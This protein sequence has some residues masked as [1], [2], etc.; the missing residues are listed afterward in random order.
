MLHRFHIPRRAWLC[1]VIPLLALNGCSY[2]DRKTSPSGVQ[3]VVAAPPTVKTTPPE[4]LPPPIARRTVDDDVGQ[5]LSAAEA[6]LAADRFTSPI[7]DNAFDRFQAVLLLRP[8]NE[9]AKSGLQQIF[10][11]YVGMIRAALNRNQLD[12][13]RTLTESARLVD[14]DH[15]IL[16]E[17]AAEIAVA[18]ERLAA[19]RLERGESGDDTEI[20]LSAQHLDRRDPTVVQALQA[21]AARIKEAEASM[22]I[23]ARSDAE[24]RWIYQQMSEG[25]PDYRLRG[26]IRV[27]SEP[28]IL[29]LPPIE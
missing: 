8:D 24:G 12:A 23:V 22:L 17:L 5:L 19:Q 7:H 20:P 3:P 18:R 2:F 11:S 26:D 4:P 29:L 13:A 14:H 9:Q 21:L 27:G 28:K 1:L 10:A 15:P 6:A 25:V 16:D